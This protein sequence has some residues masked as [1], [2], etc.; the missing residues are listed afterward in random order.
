MAWPP[1]SADLSAARTALSRGDLDQAEALLQ[2]LL[3]INPD[4]AD[5]L[6]RLAIVQCRRGD[7]ARGEAL[8]ERALK[9]QPNH[10]AALNSL[11]AVRQ[12]QGRLAEARLVLERAVTLQP[13][14]AD[15]WCNLGIVLHQLQRNAP[16]LAALE[17]ALALQSGNS[18]VLRVLARV[19]VDLE[20]PAA[21]ITQLRQA[22]TADPSLWQELVNLGIQLHY[23]GRTD[24][25][26]SA[27]EQ[28]LAEGPEASSTVLNLGAL[29]SLQGRQQE[30][31]S[32]FSRAVALEPDGAAAHLY[33]GISRLLTSNQNLGWDEF[34]WRAR[35]A[36]SMA[37]LV[38]PPGPR[39]CREQQA[40]PVDH[41]LLVGEQGLGDVLQFVRYGP[42][43]RPHAR[44][45]SICVQE[46]LVP[47]LALSGLADAVVSP[48]A[49]ADHP[50]PW[51]PL[52][53]TCHAL[54]SP[55]A[56]I[57]TP[58]PYLCVPSKR[59]AQWRQRLSPRPGELLVGVHWQGNPEAELRDAA[60]G[61]SL[62]LLLLAPL[63]EIPGLRLLSLQKGPGAEQ[64]LSCPF[65][66]AFH[67]AQAAIDTAWDFLDTAA[68]ASC[69]DLIVSADSGLVHLAGG[70][71]LPV[72]LLLKQVPDWR[73][74]LEGESCHWYPSLR[75]CRQR[76]AGD[77]PELIARL[78]DQLQDQV[79]MLIQAKGHGH[80]AGE[81]W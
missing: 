29:L 47:L 21:A 48:R 7:L 68:I 4:D 16:A 28:A 37:P 77:W 44:K 75:L 13:D 55:P 64:L 45:I 49:A 27:L 33:L 3:A 6:E 50:G 61:R 15:G 41:L 24:L 62:P 42:V 23:R 25:A 69:C 46:P 53:S 79:P 5:G 80:G 74:G 81:P 63:A 30:A 2:V 11:G 22:A 10:P 58:S 9:A 65:R 59:L 57:N 32:Y 12:N 17:R 76:I 1:M 40:G 31:L 8:L 60:R 72:W 36:T 38:T 66:R 78:C 26:I 39:W 71:G 70:L 35:V 67:P 43:F 52:L 18:R 14:L 51:L 19:L 73:W 20:R 34:E 56:T 54:A